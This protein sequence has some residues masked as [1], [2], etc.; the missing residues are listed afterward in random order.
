MSAKRYFGKHTIHFEEP[1]IAVITYHG[2]LSVEDVLALSAVGETGPHAGR[3]QLT[4][5]DARDF[6]GVDP[7][8]R[9]AAA[10]RPMTTSKIFAAYVGAS[11]AM[12][13]IITMTNRATKLLRGDPREI[14]FF[15]DFE[16][17]RA[18]LGEMRRKMLGG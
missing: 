1:D 11:F 9:K 17:A 14:A 3:F 18:W 8:A 10:R 6:G 4:I 5:V 13:A 12:R 16:S 2:R 15:D 7:E